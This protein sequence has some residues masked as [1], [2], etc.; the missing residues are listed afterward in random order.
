VNPFGIYPGH[1]FEPIVLH[2]RTEKM[3]LYREF[4]P[5]PDVV[6]FGSSRSFTVSPAEI[7]R[8]T[9]RVAFNASVHGGIP[10]D[11]LAFLRYMIAIKKVPHLA[12]V[13]LSVELL[14]SDLL[15][16]FEPYAP[17]TPYDPHERVEAFSGV[18]RL[19]GLQQTV[20]SLHLL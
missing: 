2:S 18:A 1:R 17:L 20:A 11:Y 7:R 5:P 8:L 9:G 14:R 10:R 15:R 13:C 19:L 16:G 12:L 3:A 4:E 6:V